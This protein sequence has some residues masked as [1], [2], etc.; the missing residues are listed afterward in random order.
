VCIILDTREAQHANWT[1]TYLINGAVV[2]PATALGYTPSIT[3]VGFGG[4]NDGAIVTNFVLTEQ[5]VPGPTLQVASGGPGTV[6]LSWPTTVGEYALQSS[7]VLGPA[8][9]W[10]PVTVT[11][12][13][14]GG[15]IQVT[16]TAGGKAGFYRLSRP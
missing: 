10:S 6:I 11:N 8:A 3:Y 4:L 12:Q 7:P 5:V 14:V 9:V 13:I 16:V 15:F 2:Q 1:V